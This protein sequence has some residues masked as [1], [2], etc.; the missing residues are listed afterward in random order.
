MN[1]SNYKDIRNILFGKQQEEE[2]SNEGV[3]VKLS[4]EQARDI[5]RQAESRRSPSSSSSQP[6]IN[7]KNLP[8]R[9][10]NNHG[11][12]WEARPEQFDILRDLDMSVAILELK[13][14][15]EKPSF[16]RLVL[17]TYRKH[18]FFHIFIS[19]VRDN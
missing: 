13:K 16:T 17:F 9:Y 3:M 5:T 8:P 18:I 19:H 12:L 4:K 14:V 2:S 6:I 1:Q 10:S 7:L 11:N 15:L